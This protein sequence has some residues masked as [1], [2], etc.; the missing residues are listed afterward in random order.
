MKGV[1]SKTVSDMTEAKSTRLPAVNDAI[2]PLVADY[3]KGASDAFILPKFGH[4]QS[5]DIQV[6]SGPHDLVTVADKEAEFWLVPR[7]RDLQAGHCIG[8]ET[9]AETPK[10]RQY[11]GDGYAWTIDPIDGTKAFISGVPTWSNLVGLI[12]KDIPKIGLANFP[13]LK[14]FFINNEKYSFIVNGRK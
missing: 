8:E 14:R 2:R 11:A 9:V 7:L 1:L 6:K 12:Y 4:L 10:L 5:A 3:L 13:D